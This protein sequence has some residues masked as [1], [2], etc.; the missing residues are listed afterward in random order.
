MRLGR[1]DPCHCGSGKKYKVC[2][3][4]SDAAEKR[5]SAEEATRSD[6]TRPELP[7]PRV[8]ER[9][10]AE[11]VRMFEARSR[12][13]KRA[14]EAAQEL[15]YQAWEQRSPARRIALAREAL[16]VYDGCADA[17]SLLASE[18]ARTDEEA[19]EL[20]ERAVAAA[21]AALGKRA[22]IEDVGH[23][24]GLLETRPYMRARHGLAQC[25]W[26]L[27]DRTG[28]VAD[29]Q[30]LLRL[31]PNDNQGVR[32]QLA[33]CLLEAG[34]DDALEELLARYADDAS[35]VWG[36]SAALLEFRRS[37]DGVGSR[38][39]LRAALDQNPH[40]PGYLLGE[41]KLPR[42]LPEYIGFGDEPEAIAYAAEHGDSWRG[43]RG[44]LDWLAAQRGPRAAGRMPPPR[45]RSR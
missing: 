26:H 15:M 33:A 7:D 35:A 40:V 8:F 23:F 18:D 42:H 4:D 5:A 39:V 45:R 43:T 27:G 6:D 9:S 31:N 14:A 37:G 21:E 17:Y 3:L 30:E 28:A 22:F 10:T 19:R 1:N 29:F 2:H 38:K 13:P 24:W 12:R 32:Y 20:W 25:R 11:V 16:T 41:K 36:W 44:A 34:E